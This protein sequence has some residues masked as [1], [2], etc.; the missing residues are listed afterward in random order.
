MELVV[1]HGGIDTVTTHETTEVDR[2][3]GQ[4]RKAWA[5]TIVCRDGYRLRLTSY[6]E[7]LDELAVHYGTDKG[8]EHPRLTPK[9]YTQVYERL[10][11]ARRLEIDRILEIGV[12]RGASLRMWLDYCPN[13]M[14]VGL[15]VRIPRELEDIKDYP[16][17]V[18][19]RGSQDDE[20]VLRRIRDGWKAF[21][22]IVDD[23]SHQVA[24]QQRSFIEL[25]PAVKPGG[26]YFVEDLHAPASAG[27]IPWLSGY[28][29]DLEDVGLSF[30]TGDVR[31]A[32]VQK[33]SAP[34][35]PTSAA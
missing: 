31:L 19:F 24:H 12:A 10:L 35:Y 22:F 15:D 8:S 34:E 6:E 5:N 25:W 1:S 20:V 33:K 7:R 32:A 29:E 9:C 23:G 16:R 28:V 13:A 17:L 2:R 3:T 27:F 18:L 26:F 11:G 21:D 4:R 30:V 14:V